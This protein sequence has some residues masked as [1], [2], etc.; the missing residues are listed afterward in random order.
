MASTP[1]EDSHTTAPRLAR[2]CRLDSEPKAQQYVI[3]TGVQRSGGIWPTM[4]QTFE[5]ETRF[6][7]YVMLRFTPVGMTKGTLYALAHR[8]CFPC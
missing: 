2:P 1:R 5:F 6:L 8:E 7:H 4:G 3:P